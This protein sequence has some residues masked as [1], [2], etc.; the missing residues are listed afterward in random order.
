MSE[1]GFTLAELLVATLMTLVGL[2]IAVAIVAPA[3]AAFERDAAGSDVAQRLRLGLESLADDIRGAG[4]GAAVAA[5]VPLP[6]A[7]PVIEPLTTLDDTVPDDDGFHALRLITIPAHAAQA[8][9]RE[10]LAGAN[11]IRLGG[12]PRCPSAGAVCGFEPG[13]TAIVFDGTGTYDVLEIASIDPIDLAVTPAMPLEGRYEADAIIAAAEVTTYSLSSDGTGGQRLVKQPMG[14][15]IMPLL[16]HIVSLGVTVYGTAVPPMPGVDPLEPPSY[17]PRPPWPGEDDAR[18][19][20]GAGENCTIAVREDGQREPRLPQMGVSGQLV[21]LGPEV[22]N[23][24]PWCAGNGGA[25]DFDADLL[26]IRRIDVRVRVEVASAALRGPAGRLYGR[27]GHGS[28]SIGWVP[29]GE[30]RLS[31]SP[32]NLPRP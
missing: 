7:V 10:P 18:D 25:F 2:A 12:P 4:A 6:D 22:L 8:R 20:W 11:P 14:G 31:I 5:H 24:G 29:D 16:D 21:A 32:R 17:G 30:L 13:Q 23:D 1:R 3:R 26:R 27:P 19:S 15:P 9:L 28:R